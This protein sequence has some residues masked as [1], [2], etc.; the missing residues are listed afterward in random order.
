MYMEFE[1][2]P[3]VLSIAQ[4]PHI[5]IAAKALG[6]PPEKI[7]AREIIKAALVY[8]MFAA[9]EKRHYK[10]LEDLMKRENQT[11]ADILRSCYIDLKHAGIIKRETLEMIDDMLAA[12]E[13]VPSFNR[14]KAFS[15]FCE[16]LAEKVFSPKVV[17]EAY[18]KKEEFLKA[19]AD[20][21]Q[22]IISMKEKLQALKGVEAL[23]PVVR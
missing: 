18:V 11:I 21:K 10:M 9:T 13:A 5:E 15:L 1:F 4:Y 17:E 23:T 6:V 8:G 14:Q 22:E 16:I 12:F 3:E 2:A 19:I 7:A 20:L